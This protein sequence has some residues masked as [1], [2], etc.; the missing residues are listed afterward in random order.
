MRSNN[1]HERQA[2]D[3]TRILQSVEETSSLRVR[4]KG[5]NKALKAERIIDANLLKTILGKEI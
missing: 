1:G 3:K 5:N 2:E 4:K